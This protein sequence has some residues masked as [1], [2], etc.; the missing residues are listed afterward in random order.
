MYDAFK[1]LNDISLINFYCE[2]SWYICILTTLLI[3]SA[4]L[5]WKIWYVASCNNKTFNLKLF[6]CLEYLLLHNLHTQLVKEDLIV[7]LYS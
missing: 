1:L 4:R 3:V 7:I 5:L 2:Y 6:M